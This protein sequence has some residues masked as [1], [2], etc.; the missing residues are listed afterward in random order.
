MVGVSTNSSS[1]PGLTVL[2]FKPW[3][4]LHVINGYCFTYYTWDF[5]LAVVFF[6]CF[7]LLYFFYILSFYHFFFTF[8]HFIFF[9]A[10][11]FSSFIAFYFVLLHYTFTM[12]IH[13]LIYTV[14]LL[15][16][17]LL[18]YYH[19]TW[20]FYYSITILFSSVAPLDRPHWS[21][22]QSDRVVPRW[23]TSGFQGIRPEKQPRRAVHGWRL[24]PTARP[25]PASGSGLVI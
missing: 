6:L 16:F 2:S 9:L 12:Q 21:M 8:C 5:Q 14:N 10:F 20:I 17:S 19:Y 22:L 18:I 13:S 24:V 4:R 1:A 3:V 11:I 7:R 15:S 25:Q 23:R